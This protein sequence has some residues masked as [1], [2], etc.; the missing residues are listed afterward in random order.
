M[1]QPEQG[2]S[3]HP[4]QASF[5]L[6]PDIRHPTIV[7]A[8]QSHIRIRPIRAWV[9]ENAWVKHLNV[10]SQ[11]IHV[12]DAPCDIGKITSCHRCCHVS[13]DLLR[14]LSNVF[15]AKGKS[16]QATDLAVD[17]PVRPL[18]LALRPK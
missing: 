18:R 10:D 16:E 5:A 9:E 11:L 8:A 3:A 6:L 14:F 12:L 7:C 1:P 2:Q 4:A 13:S 15:R 17:D